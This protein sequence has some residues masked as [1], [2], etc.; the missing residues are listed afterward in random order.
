MANRVFEDRVGLIVAESDTPQHFSDKLA[1]R[2]PKIQAFGGEIIRDL[3]LPRSARPADMQR[4]RDAGLYA[5]LWVAVDGLSASEYAERTLLDVQRLR[6]GAVELNIELGSDL[7]LGQYIGTTVSL[8][9]SLRKS[10]RLRVNVA[11][12][13]AFALPS[14]WLW[15]DPNLYSCEQSYEGNMDNLLSAADVLADMTAQGVPL[16]KATVCYAAACRVLGSAERVRTLPDLS[17][18]KRGVIFQDDL[19]AEVGLL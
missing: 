9:R 5:H 19:L 15:I 18:L 1:D 4:V 16:S 12:W 6:P 13:K 2:T 10:L 7:P 3:F 17:R 11:A 14:T 8:L